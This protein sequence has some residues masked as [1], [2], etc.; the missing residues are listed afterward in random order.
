MHSMRG[1]RVSRSE[2]ALYGVSA[3]GGAVT[4]LVD[5][6]Q[7]Q[8]LIQI[9]TCTGLAAVIV[10]SLL[11]T[12]EIVAAGSRLADQLERLHSELA[13]SQRTQAVHRA[14]SMAT[15]IPLPLPRDHATRPYA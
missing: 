14:D 10:R 12:R 7:V 6:N 8:N 1:G 5:S 11:Q 13:E 3:A 15:V 4:F 2:M 9:L